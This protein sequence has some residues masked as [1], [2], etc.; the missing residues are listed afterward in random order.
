LLRRYEED[1]RVND[2][3]HRWRSGTQV[4][5]MGEGGMESSGLEALAAAEGGPRQWAWPAVITC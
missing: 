2:V 1:G 5:G 3:W 4:G